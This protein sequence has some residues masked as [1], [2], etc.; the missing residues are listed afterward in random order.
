MGVSREA[1]DRQNAHSRELYQWYKAHGICPKCKTE[2][3]APGRVFCL[4]CLKKKRAEIM[5]NGSDYNMQK[6]RERR[7]KLKAQGLCVSCGKK[8][9]EGRVL[10]QVCARR[11]NEAQQVRYIKKRLHRE[12]KQ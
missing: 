6:C 7:E 4:D 8:A 11:N 9:V 1:R 2:W 5:K 3:A 12:D 10:C